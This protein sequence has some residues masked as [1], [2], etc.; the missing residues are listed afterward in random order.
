MKS[1][2]QILIRKIVREQGMVI[3][4]PGQPQHIAQDSHQWL[5]LAYDLASAAAA[6]HGRY[7]AGYSPSVGG[8]LEDLKESTDAYM[9]RLFRNHSANTLEAAY[10][11]AYRYGKELEE[12][13]MRIMR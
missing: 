3:G 4:T 6:F 7:P 8:P 11:L 10:E 2:A 1:R 5:G 12:S 13:Y 9:R